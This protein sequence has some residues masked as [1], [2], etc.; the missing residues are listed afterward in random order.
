[1]Q[2]YEISHIIDNEEWENKLSDLARR[3]KEL[4]GMGEKELLQFAVQTMPM[5]KVWLMY[6]EDFVIDLEQSKKQKSF[7][8]NLFSKKDKG[9]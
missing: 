2:F 3:C 7:F 4:N 5:Y 1:M 6:L 9:V 8:D